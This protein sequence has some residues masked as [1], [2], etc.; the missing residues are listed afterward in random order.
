MLSRC[1][2][3]LADVIKLIKAAVTLAAVAG[4][5][6]TTLRCGPAG[7]EER[8]MCCPAR[9][10]TAVACYPGGRD[11]GSSEASGIPPSF[12][13]IAVH[14]RYSCY[15][16]RSWQNIAAHQA[17]CAHLLRDYQDAAQ[18]Y[19]AAIWPAQA[20]R[21]LRGLTRAWHKARAAGQGQI[22]AGARGPLIREFRHAVPAGLS[23]VPR[24]PGP[25][26]VPSQSLPFA[27]GDGRTCSPN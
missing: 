5:D 19:P 4:F 6:E 26:N 17:C 3:V 24:I 20:Q 21:A 1:A 10:E 22:P 18:C 2:A 12:A 15:F 23:D 27:Q 13:G 14:D 8:N 7:A 11:P 9:H 25:K 16:H